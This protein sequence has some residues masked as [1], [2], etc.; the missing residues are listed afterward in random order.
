M[1][2]SGFWA[3]PGAGR[4]NWSKNDEASAMNA[5]TPSGK[6]PDLS[7]W[8]R[9]SNGCAGFGALLCIIGIV[10]D[11]HRHH[12]L[13]Q[14]GYSW[15]LAFMFWLSLV[16][17]A[18]FLVMAH[19]LCDAVWSVPIRR[20]CEHIACLLFPWMVL[21]FIPIALLAPTI[22]SWTKLDP[23]LV[24]SLRVK[25]PLLT[26]PMFHAAAV[27]CFAVWCLLA[28]KLRRWSLKQD[29][30]GS[31]VCTNRM[32][33]YSCWGMAAF[34]LTLT[35]A[36]ILWMNAIQFRW[37]STMYGVYFFAGSVWV[38]LA[39]AYLI[40]VALDRQGMLHGTMRAEHYYLLA[41]LLFA[42][43]V[44]SAYIHFSQYF[45]IWNANMP[46]ETFWYVLRERGTW[47]GVGMVI[48]FGHFLLPF[49]AL[50]RIDVKTVFRFMMPLCL[51]IALMQY[52]DLAFNITPAL[53]PDGFPFRWLWLDFGCIA[54][55]GG[56]LAR[57]F[58]R[59]LQRY[60][61]IPV[62]DPRLKEAMGLYVV[63]VPGREEKCV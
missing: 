42:F 8:R 32:R 18:L 39:A 23:Q 14:F 2:S 40:A 34:A 4:W 3:R 19:H 16:L 54:L 25:W 13:R 12:D 5:T 21:F 61:S 17:G 38:S 62:R 29:A 59:D 33:R 15:L 53:H 24:Y 7:R 46:E 1:K 63:P 52:V 58:M 36:S 49:L 10:L 27:V 30:D 20:F 11:F 57:A 45:V 22:Y 31:A 44:F 43:T 9:V 41:S 47:F 6:V 50:L 26:L 37:Y 48:V 60:P 55:M 28:F 56:V 35:L 51:W